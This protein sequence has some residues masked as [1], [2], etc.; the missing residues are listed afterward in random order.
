MSDS[1]EN[2]AEE[3]KEAE[4]SIKITPVEL[5]ETDAVRRAI[6]EVASYDAGVND[7]G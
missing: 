6:E 1:K 2:T 5:Y 7:G 3:A 4:G